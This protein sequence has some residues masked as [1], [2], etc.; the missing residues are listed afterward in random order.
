MCHTAGL[1]PAMAGRRCSSVTS[2]FMPLIL[3]PHVRMARVQVWPEALCPSAGLL[4]VSFCAVSPQCLKIHVL[5][6]DVEA[7]SLRMPH[8][9]MTSTCYLY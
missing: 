4:T 7:Q 3:M 5:D 6:V 8:L 9:H 1:L 2:W